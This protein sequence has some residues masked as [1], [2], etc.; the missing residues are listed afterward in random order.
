[1][2]S[3]TVAE[4]AVLEVLAP[5]GMLTARQITAQAHLTRWAAR[6]A[7][8]RLSA[9]GLVWQ[10]YRHAWSIAPRGRAELAEGA[11]CVG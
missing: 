8:G 5:G 7:V 4:S 2:R 11:R 10:V 3:R 1:M 6:R 9:R